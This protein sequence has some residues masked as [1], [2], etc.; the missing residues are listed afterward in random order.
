[1]RLGRAAVLVLLL[2]PP[3]AGAEDLRNAFALPLPGI[4]PAAGETLARGRASFRAVRLPGVRADGRGGLGPVFNRNACSGCHVRNGRGRP[5]PVEGAA[6]TTMV[7]RLGDGGPYG[8][9]LN[10]KAIPGVPAEGRAALVPEE[11]P[12]GLAR[13]HVVLRDLAFGPLPAAAAPSPRVA[14]HVAGAGL[15]EAVP[16]EDVLARAD[17]DDRDGDGISGR[18]RMVAAA[19]GRSRL[20]RF[21]W[22][23][24]I[25]DVRA[26]VAD[27]LAEDMGIASRDRPGPNCSPAQRACRERAGE[28]GPEIADAEFDA[29][30]LYVRLLAPPSRRDREDPEV[31][32]GEAVFRDLGCGACHVPAWEDVPS[33][34]AGAGPVTVRAYTDLLLH[35]MG[36]GLADR[37]A[38]GTAASRE[39]RTAPL[40]GIGLV[41][42]VNG[43]ARF[44]HDGRARGLGEAVLWHGGEAAAA[45][46]GYRALPAA[47]RR[48]LLRF[49]E[50][51]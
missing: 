50:S 3:R 20:G 28:G 21:G 49:L 26:Q 18:A 35:D 36:E 44:L 9:Q 47:G 10:D 6:L 46:E 12:D 4:G 48:A 14:P 5:P 17:P 39:W 31:R 51:L 41:G 33:P 43:H 19:D 7:V 42:E 27:A 32:A 11:G 25:A 1:M 29:L 37:R 23:A 40:W 2:A 22:R 15:L 38:D 24:R 34:V 30:V 8:V 45:R 13:P 16:E